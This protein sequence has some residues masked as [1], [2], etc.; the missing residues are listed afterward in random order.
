MINFRQCVLGFLALV[1]IGCGGGGGGDSIS[2]GGG[3]A[4]LD[5]FASDSFNDDYSQVWVTVHQVS[6]GDRTVFSSP[7]G[8]VLDLR[9]LRDA[10]GA[11]FS[12]LGDATMPVGSYDDI[13]IELAKNLVLVPVGGTVGQARTF[14]DRYDIG[15]AGRSE[16]RVPVRQTVAPGR[17]SLVVDFD[18]AQWTLDLSAQVVAQVVRGSGQGLDDRGR[19]ESDDYGGTLSGLAGVAPNQTF[20]LLRMGSLLDV[21]TDA[22]TRIF[23]GSGAAN[24]RLAN[25][26]RVEVTG[27]FVAGVL[28]ASAIKIEDG[29]GDDPHDIKGAVVTSDAS[30][31]RLEV[32]VSR[33]RGF[34]PDR[35]VYSVTTTTATRFLT[36]AGLPITAAEFFA[37]LT[38]GVL[39]EAEGVVSAGTLAAKKLKLENEGDAFGAEIKGR[40][41]QIDAAAG[42][43]TLAAQSWFGVN[44]NPGAS[45]TVTTNA[46]T[47][48]RL[49]NTGTGR[50]QW[51]AAMQVG[52][53]VES[54][55]QY[56]GQTLSAT[57]LKDDD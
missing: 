37:A 33:A 46:S 16:L 39:V 53:I 17:Q 41:T 8:T 28:L 11:R 1:A 55:G 12:F 35:A 31:R 23:Y 14:A 4:T 18:L 32:R 34:V 13:R 7:G 42:R 29:P 51:F 45:I 15:A 9:T 44:L 50:A 24:P 48:Y 56:N 54:K 36:D 27:V 30:A 10:S 57:R 2:T 20:R 19:H 3:T 22:S 26:L 21:R 5:L 40:I 25:N 52:S 6:L 47:T 38:A 49:G 43:L